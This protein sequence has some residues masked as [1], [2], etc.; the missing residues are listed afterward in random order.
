MPDKRSRKVL[1]FYRYPGEPALRPFLLT[2]TGQGHWPQKSRTR[3]ATARGAAISSFL[4]FVSRLF[5]SDSQNFFDAS[6][7]ASRFLRIP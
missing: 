3:L 5:P 4:G 2:H 1:E 7:F 6:D